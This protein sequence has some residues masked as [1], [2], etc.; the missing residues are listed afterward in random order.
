MNN[1][2][3][4]L[5]ANSGSR[6]AGK[7]GQGH[8]FLSGEGLIDSIY[9][10]FWAIDNVQ[11]SKLKI[12]VPETVIYRYGNPY[13]WYFTD[14]E[15]IIRKK[16]TLNLTKANIKERFLKNASASGIVATYIYHTSNLNLISAISQQER[17]ITTQDDNIGG[18]LVNEIE[19]NKEYKGETIF[20]FLDAEGFSIYIYIYI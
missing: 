5:Q 16:T 4:R 10:L 2:H 11:N 9:H 14:K 7:T 12:N 20:E 6:M 13:Y 8:Y 3:P 17:K 1:Y 19:R 15:N 18:K